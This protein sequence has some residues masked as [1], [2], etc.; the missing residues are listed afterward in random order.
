MEAT[1]LLPKSWSK[2]LSLAEGQKVEVMRRDSQ[3]FGVAATRTGWYSL[4]PVGARQPAN[5][6]LIS[7]PELPANLRLTLLPTANWQKTLH[8]L[9]P[10]VHLV[11]RAPVKGEYQLEVAPVLEGPTPFEGTRWRETGSAP[12]VAVFPRKTPWPPA[13]TATVTVSVRPFN[14]GETFLHTA[15]GSGNRAERHS[16]NGSAAHVARGRRHPA[17]AHQRR[18]G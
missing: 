2:T 8:A 15:I 7:N 11:Y 4:V 1:V 3:T 10:D 12:S 16:G 18:C 6:R 5:S 9:D 17:I 13:K 14:L